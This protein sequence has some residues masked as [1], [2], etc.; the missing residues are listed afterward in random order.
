MA[1]PGVLGLVE[2]F[3][4]DRGVVRAHDRRE[5]VD[6]A[7]TVERSRVGRGVVPVELD[8]GVMPSGGSHADSLL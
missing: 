4:D 6:S 7:D 3:G 1:D 5:Q 2:E 8:V